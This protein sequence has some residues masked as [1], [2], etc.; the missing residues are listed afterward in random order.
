MQVGCVFRRPRGDEVGVG[1]LW[2][3][4]V[5]VCFCAGVWLCG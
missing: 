5:W 3:M 2:L 1:C 4:R